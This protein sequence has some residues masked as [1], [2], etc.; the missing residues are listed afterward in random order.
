MT[1]KKRSVINRNITTSTNFLISYCSITKR[2]I[3]S[4]KYKVAQI[5]PKVIGSYLLK[6]ITALFFYCKFLKYYPLVTC[7]EKIKKIPPWGHPQNGAQR[8]LFLDLW[9]LLLDQ[10]KA[11]AK[12]HL[13]TQS[14]LWVPK[15]ISMRKNS[16][17]IFGEDK[18]LSPVVNV[19]LN[20]KG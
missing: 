14:L 5:W 3:Y 9:G 15:N 7:R 13:T 20:S 8:W 6:K 16:N 12:I 2:F 10:N 4:M 11:G 1:D 19:V 17:S 18:C